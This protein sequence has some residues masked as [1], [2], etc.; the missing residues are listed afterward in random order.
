MTLVQVSLD[1][2]EWNGTQLRRCE[3]ELDRCVVI[4]VKLQSIHDC[5]ARWSAHLAQGPRRFARDFM[6][7][8]E[9]RA[10]I[11]DRRC[12]AK[13]SERIGGVG[14][15]GKVTIPEQHAKAG[16]AR[17]S[18]FGSDLSNGEGCR[19]AHRTPFAR[20]S[21]IDKRHVEL[22]CVRHRQQA[23]EEIYFTCTDRRRQVLPSSS[24]GDS[25]KCGKE[26]QMLTKLHSL[27][28]C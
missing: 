3:Q 13:Q 2:R 23:G 27:V 15:D 9:R 4:M 21:A 6:I 17:H 1:V 10:E 20:Q 5:G 25:N 7:E 22:P 8:R 12:I 18:G 16:R 11:G 28:P 19:R 24:Y 14:R 26:K